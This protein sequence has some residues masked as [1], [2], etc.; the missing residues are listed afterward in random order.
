MIP[1]DFRRVL[2]DQSE[3]VPPLAFLTRIVLLPAGN[4]LGWLL[5]VLAFSPYSFFDEVGRIPGVWMSAGFAA[6]SM[7]ID[8][9][10][11]RRARN[12]APLVRWWSPYEGG[13]LLVFPSWMVGSFFVLFA[14]WV[15][16]THP[17]P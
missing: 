11:R 10:F 15:L 1:V 14:I 9:M 2:V 12:R 6:I 5:L 4:L 8:V 7:A 17:G 3:G 13:T 16:V